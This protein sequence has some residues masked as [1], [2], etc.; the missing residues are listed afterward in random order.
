MKSFFY[1]CIAWKY[2]S[3]CLRRHGLQLDA[4][5]KQVTAAAA[6]VELIHMDQQ[7][8]YTMHHNTMVEEK[9]YVVA[10]QTP[11]RDS[12]CDDDDDDDDEN[13]LHG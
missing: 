3:P 9:A 7:R 12:E 5:V 13:S 4:L 6:G 10:P 11:L 1:V 2:L 8:P